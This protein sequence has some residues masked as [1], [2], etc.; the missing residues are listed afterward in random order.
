MKKK[1]Y[2]KSKIHIKFTAFDLVM[3]FIGVKFVLKISVQN[4]ELLNSHR[5]VHYVS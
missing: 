3:G 5:E 4:N 2:K 1:R